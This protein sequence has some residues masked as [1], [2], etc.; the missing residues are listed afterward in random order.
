MGDRCNIHEGCLATMICLNP[1][2]SRTRL[3]CSAC[4]DEDT[5]KFHLYFS[6]FK[7]RKE[8]EL[9]VS[10]NHVDNPYEQ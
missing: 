8:I 3:M 4:I 9:L 6:A 1:E 5:H 7:F 2:C 10:K